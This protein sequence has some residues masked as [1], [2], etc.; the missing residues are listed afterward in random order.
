MKNGFNR[1]SSL[2]S[3]SFFLLAIIS[4]SSCDT[5]N[6]SQPQPIDKENIYEFPKEMQGYWDDKDENETIRIN[7]N[8]VEFIKYLDSERI[9]RGAWLQLS[10]KESSI[11][12][13]F[14]Y[15]TEKT[16]HY[17]SLKKPI[18]TITNYIV[19]G[20]Y[21]YNV[22]YDGSLENGYPFMVDK[23]TII[24]LK[25]D[26]FFIDLG[27]NAF[28][29]KLTEKF[30]VLNINNSILNLFKDSNKPWWQVIILERNGKEL[31]E[32]N[33]TGKIAD[34]PSMFYEQSGNYYFDSK[35]T[36]DEM[37]QLINNGNCKVEGKLTRIKEQPSP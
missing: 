7:A 29:R 3:L 21:I 2:I 4:I 31:N 1:K 14:L 12:R 25:R 33:W 15:N 32:W 24:I 19:R 18:D 37:M 35:W 30:Y 20:Q 36:T 9:V 11:E 17:D 22:Q 26:T 28:L 5:F 23:D 8:N 34:R 27:K 10:A 13:P 6:F 16:I